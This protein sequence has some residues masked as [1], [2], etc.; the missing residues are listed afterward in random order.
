MD[1]VLYFLWV[2]V[3]FKPIP[4]PLCLCLFVCGVF[5]V[6][7]YEQLVVD[8]AIKTAPLGGIDLTRYMADMLLSCKVDTLTH[9]T[10]HPQGRQLN[11]QQS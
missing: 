5:K 6:P 10:G 3:R 4:L 7:V 9:I 8:V 1:V 2:I 11:H